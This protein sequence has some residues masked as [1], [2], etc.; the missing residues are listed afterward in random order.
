MS[1]H[2][3]HLCQ[4]PGVQ[5]RIRLFSPL[6][7]TF[8]HNVPSLHCLPWVWAV[9]CQVLL[10]VLCSKTD[11]ALE[12]VTVVNQLSPLMVAI[13]LIRPLELVGSVLYFLLMFS[14][15]WWL[16]DGTAVCLYRPKSFLSYCFIRDIFQECLSACHLISEAVLIFLIPLRVFFYCYSLCSTIC[17]NHLRNTH[18]IPLLQKVY[19]IPSTRNYFSVRYGWSKY[20]E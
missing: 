17:H 15:H 5:H 14:H 20:S 4:S 10:P 3:P 9:T 11:L 6:F 2:H 13:Y 12:A 19:C 16:C 18:L 7:G 1:W 8:L